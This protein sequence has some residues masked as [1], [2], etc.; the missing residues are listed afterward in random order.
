MTK[1]R[2]EDHQRVNDILLGKLERKF[3]SWTCAR[4]PA[5]V[6][7]DIL[8]LVAFLAGIVIA[9]GYALTNIS[10]GFFWMSSL[11]LALHWFGDSL[12]GS[13]AR[14]RKIERPQY[15]YFIDHSLDTLVE[16][17][18][19]LGIGLS[20]Y[21][22]MDCVLF[23]LIAY[24]MMSVLVSIRAFVTGVFQISYGRFGPTEL[25]VVIIIA[26]TI[27]FFVKNPTIGYLYGPIT[28]CDLIALSIAA[29]LIVAFILTTLQV[30][31]KLRRNDDSART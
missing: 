31:L 13:L 29:F 5:W 22:R 18:I 6:T 14:Y 17:I 26:N 10:K 30:A 12:D 28:I 15:G 19:C 1:S 11:G 9:T 27:F 25:R 20:P 3:L 2:I 23:T 4:L 7:P 16:V 21:V 8:T 24:L